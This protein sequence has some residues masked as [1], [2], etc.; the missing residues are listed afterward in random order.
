MRNKYQTDEREGANLERVNRAIGLQSGFA[1]KALKAVE[2]WPPSAFTNP[3]NLISNLSFLL[4]QQGDSAF[5]DVF[6]FLA[7]GVLNHVD[8]GSLGQ[9]AAFEGAVP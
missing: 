4:L 3:I 9:F 5:A 1:Y 8:V 6:E 7:V 2:E